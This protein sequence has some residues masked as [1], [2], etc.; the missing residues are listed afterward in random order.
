MEGKKLEII[1]SICIFDRGFW[2]TFIE[3]HE[4]RCTI[5]AN[6]MNYVPDQNKCK[7]NSPCWA[8]V[9]TKLFYFCSLFSPET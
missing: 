9:G 3:E 1:T 6:Y 4:Q 2:A 5:D 8:K 7:G